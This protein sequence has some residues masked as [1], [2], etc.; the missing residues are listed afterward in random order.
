MIGDRSLLMVVDDDDDIRELLRVLLEAEGYRV[1]TA[2]DGRDAWRQLHD[3]ESPKLILLDLMMPGMDGQDFM[4][5]LRASP[6]AKIPVIVMSGGSESPNQAEQ[7]KCD[8]YLTKPVELEDL[9]ATI[10]QF[11]PDTAKPAA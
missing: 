1:V 6:K 7:L 4:S 11:L 8:R 10:Q 3:N 2:A 5:T 9:L